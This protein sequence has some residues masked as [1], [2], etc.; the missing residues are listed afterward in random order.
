MFQFIITVVVLLLY[1]GVGWVI[2]EIMHGL[3]YGGLST[4]I[5][6]KIMLFWPLGILFII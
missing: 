1:L 6:I 2:Q 3:T 4:K 5:R